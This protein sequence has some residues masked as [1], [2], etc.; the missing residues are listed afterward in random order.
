MR[1]FSPVC[2]LLVAS[3]GVIAPSATAQVRVVSLQDDASDNGWVGGAWVRCIAE[4]HSRAAGYAVIMGDG[5]PQPEAW[6]LTT[7]QMI[8]AP[9]LAMSYA[10]S[11][12]NNGAV[13]ATTAD[14]MWA[15]GAFVW[16]VG[17]AT[18]QTYNVDRVSITGDGLR[19]ADA[20]FMGI[21]SMET[22]IVNHPAGTLIATV[23]GWGVIG[24]DG[25]TVLTGTHV[26]REGVGATDLR[27][28][29]PANLKLDELLFV[30]PDGGTF[31]GRLHCT[32]SSSNCPVPQGGFLSRN[33]EVTVW[34]DRCP[35]QASRGGLVLLSRHFNS[36]SYGMKATHITTPRYGELTAREF[37]AREAPA[38]LPSRLGTWEI[39]SVSP[40]GRGFVVFTGHGHPSHNF[41]FAEL[42]GDYL[43]NDIDFNN[44]GLWPDTL[45][46]ET[47]LTVFS[48]G[49]MGADPPCDPI[50]F[51]NDGLFP[52]TADIEAFLRVFSGGTCF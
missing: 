26:W 18:H 41:F 42:R 33:G 14:N 12:T 31:G 20:V 50:D 27:P 4:D 40:N 51:N 32:T 35:M 9:A 2:M 24:V 17:A 25:N 16:D 6:D 28:L 1:P 37:F 36:P 5:G 19:R 49:C 15:S 13:V 8:H 22:R 38:L 23:P 43:C 52:D 46:I 10:T 7:G 39:L 34:T 21:S 45:D 3:A 44:D 47:F 29:W 11:I 48:D 30:S